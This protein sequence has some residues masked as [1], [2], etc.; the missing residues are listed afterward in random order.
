[1]GK[2]AESWQGPVE[3][4]WKVLARKDENFVLERKIHLGREA[5]KCRVEI[6]SDKRSSSI[7]PPPHPGWAVGFPCSFLLPFP[8]ASSW[9]MADLLVVLCCNCCLPLLHACCL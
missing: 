8:L 6:S 5:K 4:K 1:M 7:V 2:T 3:A 9:W